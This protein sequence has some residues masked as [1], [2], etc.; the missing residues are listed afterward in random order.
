M[1]ISL[2]QKGKACLNGINVGSQLGFEERTL[3]ATVVFLTQ[4]WKLSLWARSQSSPF[5]LPFSLVG[6]FRS[7]CELSHLLVSH[8]LGPSIPS[9]HSVPSS[10][11]VLIGLV[12]ILSSHQTV[13]SLPKRSSKTVDPLFSSF[14]HSNSAQLYVEQVLNH[15][16]VHCLPSTCHCFV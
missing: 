8:S 14:L 7:S 2:C 11:T 4:L 10:T 6:D 1:E 13:S 15:C 3:Y 5:A 9:I 12:Y 16:Q